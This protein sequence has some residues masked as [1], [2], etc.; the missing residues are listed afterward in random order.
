MF[1]CKLYVEGVYLHNV[2][3]EVCNVQ[4]KSTFGRCVFKGCLFS[5]CIWSVCI[6]IMYLEGVYSQNVFGEVC[7]C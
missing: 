2:F 7:I 4:L 1:T 6:S 3:G 5:Q